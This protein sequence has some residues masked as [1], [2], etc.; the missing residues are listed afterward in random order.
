MYRCLMTL[1]VAFLLA[2]PEEGQGL[3]STPPAVQGAAEGAARGNQQMPTKVGPKTLSPPVPEAASPFRKPP[4]QNHPHPSSPTTSKGSPTSSS[5][6]K[7]KVE[8]PIVPSKKPPGTS[9]PSMPVP[10]NQNS[11]FKSSSKKMS[12]STNTYRKESSC[13][14]FASLTGGLL[15]PDLPAYGLLGS[16]ALKSDL[17]LGAELVFN[18]LDIEKNQ[19]VKE[20]Y[21][22]NISLRFL[23]IGVF[24]HK[25]FLFSESFYIKPALSYRV[26]ETGMN[27]YKN[28]INGDFDFALA[29][30][31][32]YLVAS[33]SLGNRY[34]LLSG[35]TIGCDWIGI[36]VPIG[37]KKES[38]GQFNGISDPELD[39]TSSRLYKTFLKP[40]LQLFFISLG[41]TF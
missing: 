29:T 37:L 14:R 12:C 18:S 9:P 31:S 2:F 10:G 32:Q 40:H 6:P 5:P 35:L 11:V 34:T 15:F 1:I 36:A 4:I 41:W 17:N 20:L 28:T 39:A 7:A 19:Q 26:L 3:D 23:Q 38:S 22:R 24:L 25:K 33:T 8:L 30:K 13:R 16:Y 21:Y 27:G